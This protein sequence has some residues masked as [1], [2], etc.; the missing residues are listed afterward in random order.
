MR[1]PGPAGTKQGAGAPEYTPEGYIGDPGGVP[2]GLRPKFSV[3][4]HVFGGVHIGLG[5]PKRTQ[6]HRRH[7][8]GKDISGPAG[9]KEP[10]F[11]LRLDYGLYLFPNPGAPID[12]KLGTKSVK[13]PPSPGRA[14]T[15]L[16]QGGAR[17][18]FPQGTTLP[19]A[20]DMPQAYGTPAGGPLGLRPP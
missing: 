20:P 9:L 18:G 4:R 2:L 1:R 15:P 8:G 16:A 6:K 14:S 12:H 19:G 17:E 7:I 13:C 10:W 3:D 5:D 11:G